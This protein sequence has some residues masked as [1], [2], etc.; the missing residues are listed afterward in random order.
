M[1]VW[2]YARVSTDE[3][4]QGWSL[5]AQRDAICHAAAARS[6]PEPVIVEEVAS[7]AGERPNLK[8]LLEKLE[9]GDVL[10]IYS[11]DRLSRSAR[12]LLAI[13]E[14]LENKGIHLI[15]IREGE[16]TGAVGKLIYG[17]LAAVADFEREL[18]RE[19]T[20]RGL[21][22]ARRAGKRVGR[23]RKYDYEKIRR[24]AEKLLKH[25]YNIKQTAR[26]LGIPP[27]QLRYILTRGK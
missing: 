19:R 7:G 11:I 1:R 21:E 22:A 12:E 8:E 10:I 23:P 26:L 14:L 9:K 24:E 5:D 4:A 17:V 2:G 6:Y 18:I 15:T 27:S 13:F 3:Q 16:F 20:R 25:G